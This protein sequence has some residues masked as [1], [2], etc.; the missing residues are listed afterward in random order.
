MMHK[1]KEG[2]AGISNSS[3]AYI[4]VMPLTSQNIASLVEQRKVFLA[5]VPPPG[6]VSANGEEEEK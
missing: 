2:H 1:V 4:L 5:G 6:M 3:I